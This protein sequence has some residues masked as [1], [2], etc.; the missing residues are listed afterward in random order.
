MTRGWI[1]LALLLALM[2]G[3]L[4]SVYWLQEEQQVMGTRMEQAAGYALESRQ[5]DA[6]ALA[7]QVKRQ[8]ERNWNRVAAF[9]DH[10][11]MEE[12]DGLFAQLDVYARTGDDVAWAAICA[13]LSQELQALGDAAVPHWWNL[14]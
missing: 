1:G 2:V 12:I 13:E 11:P 14:L 7:G 6:Q 4:V 8:W 3:S 5:E 10:G 9:A